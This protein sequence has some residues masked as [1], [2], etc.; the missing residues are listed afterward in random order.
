MV[1]T[2]LQKL[3]DGADIMEGLKGLV[4]EQLKEL[5]AMVKNV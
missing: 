5:I 3:N 4:P 1:S 2:K